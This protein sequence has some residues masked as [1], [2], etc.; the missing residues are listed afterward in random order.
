MK[1]G[2]IG[3]GLMGSRMAK[4]LIKNNKELIVYNRT[5][6]KAKEV[7]ELGAEF[8]ESPKEV[9][10]NSDV[11]FTMLSN[12]DAVSNLALGSDGFLNSMKQNSIWVDCSTVNPS[13]S[14]TVSRIAKGMDVRFVDAPVAGTIY[15]AEKGELI[16][17]VGGE[18]K[19]VEEIKP[20]LECM[21]KK[22]IHVGESGKGT[23]LKI[24]LNLL[25]GNAMSAF[26]EAIVLGE[27]MG[28]S[29]EVLLNTIIGGPL[30]APF[31]N[32]K[33]EKISTDKYETEF[34][35]EY[36]HKDLQLASVT[37]F[38]NDVPL[39][40]TNSSK[41]IFGLAKNSGLGN[42]DFSAVYKYLADNNIK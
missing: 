30:A 26:S 34:P 39:M 21:G 15:P 8:S 18:K 25:L 22:I 29:K 35:L 28:I 27:S 24:V 4:N 32:G 7:I 42:K 36:M 12:P 1:I 14:V 5:K 9:G 33:K 16:F 23:S 2:F 37:G 20:L 3:L 31:L 11:V 6:E 19:D 10:K 17:T 13:F 41:E 38:E 40:L